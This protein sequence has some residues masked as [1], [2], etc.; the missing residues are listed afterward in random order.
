MKVRG[1]GFRGLGFRD[2]R[3]FGFRGLGVRV[4]GGSPGGSRQNIIVEVGTQEKYTTCGIMSRN[5]LLAAYVDPL[6]V[7][8]RKNRHMPCLGQAQKREPTRKPQAPK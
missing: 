7:M 4:G 8:L 2:F 1:L 5:S 6:G 3:G